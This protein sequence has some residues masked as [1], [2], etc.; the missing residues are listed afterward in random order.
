V[1]WKNKKSDTQNSGYNHAS[2]ERQRQFL[3]FLLRDIVFKTMIKIDLV[4]GVEN[5]PSEGPA[6]LVINHIAFVDPIVMVHVVPRNIVPLAKIEVYDYPVIG[7]IPRW[8]GGIT[9]RREEMDRQAVRQAMDVLRA[10][11]IILVAPDGTRNPQL[12]RAKEGFAYFA[13]RSAAPVVPIAIEG[14]EHFP[15]YP[16]SSSWRRQG[17]SVRFFPPFRYKSGSQRAKREELRLMTDEAMYYLASNLPEKRR[18][19]Y[20]DL[21]KATQETIEFL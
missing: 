18:G 15:T 12:M 20:S 7:I 2:W 5:V 1:S 4:E 8:W 11:E 13:S 3:R 17:V 9:V 21:S 10:G 19:V 16:L 14:S 6:V